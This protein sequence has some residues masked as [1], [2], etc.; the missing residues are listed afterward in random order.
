[1]WPRYAADLEHVLSQGDA[2]PQSQRTG[3]L[4]VLYQ[5]W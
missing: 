4:A 1:M 2:Q 3:E 5:R